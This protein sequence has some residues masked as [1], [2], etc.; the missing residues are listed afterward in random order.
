ME[1]VQKAL[2][3]TIKK[4]E[5]SP[6]APPASQMFQWFEE[7]LA[8]QRKEPK[9]PGSFTAADYESC[10]HCRGS[11]SFGKPREDG[12]CPWCDKLVVQQEPALASTP[13]FDPLVEQ[14]VAALR[15]DSAVMCGPSFDLAKWLQGGMDV[16]AR[17]AHAAG[18]AA[19]YARG[20]P[21][22]RKWPERWMMHDDRVLRWNEKHAVWLPCRTSNLA[23]GDLYIPQPAA[24]DAKEAGR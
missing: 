23:D 7:A 6:Y 12:T 22:P 24:P 21:K 13:A 20:C 15:R 14:M 2:R 17:T 5:N 9:M 19:G 16:Y 10:P 4:I 18:D 8:T 3:E 11:F 1:Q